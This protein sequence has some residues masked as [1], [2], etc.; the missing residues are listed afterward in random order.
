MIDIAQS[1][2][3]TATMGFDYNLLAT[4][5]RIDVGITGRDRPGVA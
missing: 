1:S 3:A 5:A 2:V 4:M